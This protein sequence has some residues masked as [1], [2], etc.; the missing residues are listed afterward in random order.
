[1][2]TD[3]E[4]LALLNQVN[5]QLQPK[6]DRLDKLEHQVKELTN[7]K[8]QGPKVVKSRSKRVQQA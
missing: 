2:L 3:R 8:E 1:M 4:F 6:W 5:N 7:A